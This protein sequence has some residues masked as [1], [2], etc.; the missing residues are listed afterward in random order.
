M[1]V[2]TSQSYINEDIVKE[3]KAMLEGIESIELVVWTTGIQDFNGEDVFILADG[4]HTY[5]AAV[6]LGIDVNFVEE[7]H[8][9]G[10][11]GE[12]LLDIA[13]MDSDYCYLG[14]TCTVW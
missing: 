6:E 8:P 2:I 13:W 7:E 12:A 9:E 4:H 10:V 11:T 14:T 1:K 5:T 3:K